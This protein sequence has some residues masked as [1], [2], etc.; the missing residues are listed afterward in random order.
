MCTLGTASEKL[1]NQDII[2]AGVKHY[3]KDEQIVYRGQCS[4]VLPFVDGLGRIE[5]ENHLQVMNR[6]TG[7]LS[8]FHN[9]RTGLCRIDNWN[10]H[11]LHLLFRMMSDKQRSRL[12]HTRQ[13]ASI[14][15]IQMV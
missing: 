4:S 12:S 6:Q 11:F 1:R 9:I 13:A 10:G 7:R 15:Q 5:T 14:I 3:C 2:N 8:E